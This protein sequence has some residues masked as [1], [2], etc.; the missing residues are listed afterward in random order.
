MYW[1]PAVVCLPSFSLSTT[2]MCNQLL[3]TCCPPCYYCYCLPRGCMLQVQF[4]FTVYVHFM[5]CMA[6]RCVLSRACR[7]HECNYLVAWCTVL[8]ALGYKLCFWRPLVNSCVHVCL[9]F[10]YIHYWLRFLLRNTYIMA[11]KYSIFYN[12]LHCCITNIPYPSLVHP[13]LAYSLLA[14]LPAVY[15]LYASVMPV[16][17]YSILGTSKHISVGKLL[18]LHFL[19]ATGSN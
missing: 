18:E 12:R 2:N 3:F 13:G 6:W 5:Y 19:C 8:P 1:P 14:T 9:G 4:L 7:P 11:A 10:A 16:V 15:G 17:V